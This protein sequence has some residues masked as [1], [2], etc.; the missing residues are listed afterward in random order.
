[1]ALLAA[2]ILASMAT[3]AAGVVVQPSI[4]GA[5]LIS[6]AN[7]IA[8]AGR[9]FTPASYLLTVTA[10][11]DTLIPR[12][13]PPGL[14]AASYALSVNNERPS[15]RLR[16]RL[17]HAILDEHQPGCRGA[18]REEAEVLLRKTSD[19]RG[20]SCSPED[21]PK[22]CHDLAH[23]RWMDLNPSDLPQS[24][25]FNDDKNFPMAT[26]G[27]A[28]RRHLGE[29]RVR[30]LGR[31]R[32]AL[33]N[34]WRWVDLAVYGDSMQRKCLFRLATTRWQ[35]SNRT[36]C[37]N[38]RSTRGAQL[39][40]AT[41]PSCRWTLMTY[42]RRV[43]RKA[44]SRSSDEFLRGRDSRSTRSNSMW[45]RSFTGTGRENSRHSWGGRPRRS[46]E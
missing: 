32:T 30:G 33:S 13:H 3:V 27:A 44:K 11:N 12:R 9:H 2:A 41:R 7:Q 38:G 37:R 35:Q 39:C 34:A 8:I 29:H 4:S 10:W 6:T 25:I 21:S 15:R 20:K 14:V 16:R 1:M 31:Q 22:T 19:L 42:R 28:R 17:R 43:T 46:S 5:A 24:R 26:D 45:Q 23:Y 36:D 18:A 40:A